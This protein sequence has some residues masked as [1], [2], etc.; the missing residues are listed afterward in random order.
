MC[1]LRESGMR[2]TDGSFRRTARK[3]INRCPVLAKLNLRR[4]LQIAFARTRIGFSDGSK[5]N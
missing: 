2:S 1:D 4:N 5:T 3:R